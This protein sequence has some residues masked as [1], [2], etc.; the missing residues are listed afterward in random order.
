MTIPFPEPTAPAGSRTEVLVRY[1][2][3]YR[4]V[5]LA[6]VDGLTEAQLRGSI[7]PSGWSPLELVKHLTYV[8]LRWLEW[9]FEGAPLADPWGDHEGER[10]QVGDDE[11]AADL[12]AALQT[13]GRVTAA[14]AHR[15]LL[16]DVGAPG[17]RWDGAPPA[18]LERCLLHVM[19]EY[20]RH[21]GHLDVVREL[22]DGVTGES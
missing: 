4:A 6:K 12:L 8:E 2:D 14:I 7:L 5:V 15:H 19:Q 11:A 9:G 21:L 3:Y 20:A 18:T 17:E 13:R 22:L 1:L 10:W 16:D